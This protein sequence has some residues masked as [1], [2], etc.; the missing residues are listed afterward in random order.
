[1]IRP[2]NTLLAAAG[3]VGMCLAVS[4]CVSDTKLSGYV[5]SHKVTTVAA[6]NLALDE[7]RAALAKAT[8]A[9]DQRGALAAQAGV[10]TAETALAIVGACPGGVVFSIPMVE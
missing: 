7:A 9:G 3:V 4:A 10:D 1:M 5:C 6:A 2:I 8:A